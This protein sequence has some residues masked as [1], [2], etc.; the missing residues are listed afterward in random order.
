MRTYGRTADLLGNRTWVQVDTDAAGNDDAVNLTAL[1]QTLQLNVGESPFFANTG[2]PQYQSVMTQVFPDYYA[3]L[4]QS[5]YSP[6][7]TSLTI[8]RVPNTDKPEYTIDAR[9]H[10]GAVLL[11]PVPT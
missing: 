11:D 1:A 9:T 3:M 2:I 10:H 5:E 6:Y 4:I 7:F 8:A